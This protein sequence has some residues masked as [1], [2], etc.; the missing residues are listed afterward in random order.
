MRRAYCPPD[1]SLRD[2][3]LLRLQVTTRSILGAIAHD[4]GGVIVAEGRLRILGSGTTRSLIAC[5]EPA[6]GM[7]TGAPDDFN[8]RRR[9]CI[10]RGLRTERR[11][12]RTRGSGRSLLPRC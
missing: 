9:R 12:F 7:R 5:N 6:G 8:R 3:T 1:E 10:G 2:R 4:S 11:P